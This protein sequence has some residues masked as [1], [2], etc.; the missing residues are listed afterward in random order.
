MHGRSSVSA[1]VPDERHQ[2]GVHVARQWP[3]Q[4]GCPL[5]RLCRWR[6]RLPTYVVDLAGGLDGLFALRDLAQPRS[7]C[8]RL[9][10]FDK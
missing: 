2:A 9:G 6:F 5:P 1:V 10:A 8:Y 3:R 4:E 7:F